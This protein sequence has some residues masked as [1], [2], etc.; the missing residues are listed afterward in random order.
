MKFRGLA[1]FICLLL[2]SGSISALWTKAFYIRPVT[3]KI[4]DKVT[5]QPMEN[6]PVYYVIQS[7]VC[8]QFFPIPEPYVKDKLEVVERYL[9]SSQGEIKIKGRNIFLSRWNFKYIDIEEIVINLENCRQDIVYDKIFDIMYLTILT[10][11][12]EGVYNPNPKYHGVFILNSYDDY[13][14][15]RI[16]TKLADLNWNGKSLSKKEENL[17]IELEPWENK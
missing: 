9:S 13:N 6:I 12:T 16:R 4:I 8:L 5:G 2:T 7:R 15:D 3:I 17:T 14:N 1:I 10:N 11:G